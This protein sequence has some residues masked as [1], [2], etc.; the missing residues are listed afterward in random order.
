LNGAWKLKTRTI[1]LDANVRLNENL[2]VAL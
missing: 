1:M 2:S